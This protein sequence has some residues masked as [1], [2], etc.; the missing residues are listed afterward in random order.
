MDEIKTFIEKQKKKIGLCSH[1]GQKRPQFSSS[2]FYYS[3][4]NGCMKK[5]DRIIKW[6]P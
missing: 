3:P 1:H 5:S 2:P 4:Q 6:G